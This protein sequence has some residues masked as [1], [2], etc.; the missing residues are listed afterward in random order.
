M[1]SGRRAQRPVDVRHVKVSNDDQS[2]D[3]VVRQRTDVLDEL[4]RIRSNRAWRTVKNTDHD[5]SSIEI[6]KLHFQIW[7]LQISPSISSQ[8]FL[9]HQ[10]KTTTMT[11]PWL[12]EDVVAPQVGENVVHIFR[13]VF[14][15]NEARHVGAR[16][17]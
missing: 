13:A 7:W 3:N 11:I 8:G 5:I 17:E 6:N 1:Y 12:S 2:A 9:R 15:F 14:R 4:C 16:A 10:S